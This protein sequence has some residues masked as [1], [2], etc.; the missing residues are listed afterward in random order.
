MENPNE[1]FHRNSGQQFIERKET[2]AKVV[3]MVSFVGWKKLL[4]FVATCTTK[5]YWQ[6]KVFIFFSN[7]IF[8]SSNHILLFWVLVFKVHFAL[9]WYKKTSCSLLMG[10]FIFLKRWCFAFPLIS[11]EDRYWKHM[12]SLALLLF[13]LISVYFFIFIFY[14]EI[15][16]Q[17]GDMEM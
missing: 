1:F 4:L 13:F 10:C 15:C 2:L 6:A 12:L 14:P 11:F 16:M 8:R 7:N 3:I 5:N 17:C 9:L